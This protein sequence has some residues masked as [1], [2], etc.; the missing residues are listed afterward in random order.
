MAVAWFRDVNQ[1]GERA[2]HFD[3]RLFVTHSSGF[4]LLWDEGAYRAR[5]A[6]AARMLREEYPEHAAALMAR[7]LPL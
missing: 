5:E 7:G 4:T 1:L 3:I 2:R 6:A